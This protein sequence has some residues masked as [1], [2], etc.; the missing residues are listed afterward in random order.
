MDKYNISTSHFN[1]SKKEKRTYV[2]VFC[3]NSTATQTTLRK[4]YKKICPAKKCEI[5]DQSEIWNEKN[6]TFILD[7]VDGDNHNNEISN[8]R[9][10]CP[11][12]DSQL[13]TYT[14]RNNKKRKNI[15]QL[16]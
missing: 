3:P 7:H 11:N 10:I 15:C 1:I 4:W 16:K 5:C 14:G 8:L 13:P 12:C 9:W 6:L 2:T